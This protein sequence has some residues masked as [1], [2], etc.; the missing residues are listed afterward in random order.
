MKRFVVLYFSLMLSGA[1]SSI[2]YAQDEKEIDTISVLKEKEDLLE[3]H[4]KHIALQIKFLEKKQQCIEIE[5][6]AE[7][8]GKLADK[9]VED[10]QGTKSKETRKALAKAERASKKLSKIKKQIRDLENDIRSIE[11]KITLQ[12]YFLEIKEK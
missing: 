7:H 6:K 10:Y 1:F 11:R 4:I 5:Q 3:L 2:L 9:A 12:N 8:L